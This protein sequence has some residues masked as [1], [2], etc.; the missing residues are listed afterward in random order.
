M[1]KNIIEDKI[2][3][4]IY[5]VRGKQVMLDSDLA[6][7]Y[8]VETKNLN[9]AVKR[10]IQRFPEH[11]RFQLTNNEYEHILRFSFGTSNPNTQ[12]GRRYLPYVFTEQGI[13]MLSSVLKSDIAVEVSIKI[14]DT[15]VN[16]RKFLM[17]NA[18]IF[19]RID[20]IEYKLLEHDKK[21]DKVFIAMNSQNLKP[22]QG[23][24]HDR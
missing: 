16:L 4:K 20:N 8:Q 12:G 5:S 2:S 7:L 15:F 22:V 11:F 17:S 14:I 3:Q 23:I 24:F 9:K 18:S 19:Q 6:K 1:E 13:S 21:I 10:N